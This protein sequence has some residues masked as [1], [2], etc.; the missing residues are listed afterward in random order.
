M[1]TVSIDL[2]LATIISAVLHDYASECNKSES[3]CIGLIKVAN[4]L[5]TRIIESLEGRHK[6]E[7]SV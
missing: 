7:K 4:E 2:T 1:K 3:Y 5:D 6:H